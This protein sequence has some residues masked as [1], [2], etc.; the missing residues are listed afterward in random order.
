[1]K[2]IYQLDDYQR[3]AAAR[4]PRVAF[5]YVSGGAGSEA[6]L[7]RN[8]D[9][10]DQTT[11]APRVLRRCEPRST[12]TNLLGQQYA[13]PFGIAPMGLANLVWPGSDSALA[14]AARRNNL[15][16][17]LSTAASTSVEEIG[18]IAAPMLWFQLYV[19]RDAAITWDLMRRARAAA[20]DTLVVT[21]DAAAPGKRLRDLRNG[22][23]LPLKPTWRTLL[24]IASRPSWCLA[25][26]R[27]GAPRF[28][29]LES[30]GEKRASS[31][32]I[33]QF[34]AEQAS[35]RLDWH[36]LGEIRRRWPGKLILKGLLHPQDAMR[37]IESG[38]DAIIV[39]NHGGRQLNCAVAP[40]AALPAIRRAVGA[41]ATLLLD[42]GVRTGE[43]VIIAIATGA[44]F[45][46]IGRPFLYC[47]AARGAEEGPEEAI[48]IL[49]D[50][51]DRALAHVGFADI[52][53]LRAARQELLA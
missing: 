29:N 20:V 12:A 38:V 23:T 16:F 6:A 2:R 3:F 17:T 35:A 36:L 51:I 15:P 34:M 33:A 22:L 1:M 42:G 8:Q 43:A 24:D 46:L 13:V 25:T 30:Y 44:D 19:G 53:A 14:R 28:A 49:T 40:L 4:I 47:V 31:V 11:L 18:A 52:G 21:L 27:A 45:V 9:A 5:D 26:L 39:S 10:F 32:A 37:A 7:R 48:R 50:E 41:T